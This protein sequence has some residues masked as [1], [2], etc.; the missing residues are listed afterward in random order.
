MKDDVGSQFVARIQSASSVDLPTIVAYA[1]GNEGPARALLNRLRQ[2]GL[3]ERVI[4]SALAV[5]LSWELAQF[6]PGNPNPVLA[7]MTGMF[8]INLTIA[9]SVRDAIQRM[10]GVMWGVGVALLIHYLF[11]LH[12]WTLAL[13][14]AIS[15]AGGRRIGLE[16]SGLS[17]MAASALLVILGAVGSR[18]DNV[19]W[20][21]VVNTLVGTAVGLTLNAVIAPPNYLPSAR[22]AL[23]KL[24]ESLSNLQEDIAATLAT[25]I[26]QE[27][28]FQLL[29]QARAIAATVEKVDDAIGSGEASLKY[30]VLN[31][32]QVITLEVYRRASRALEHAAVQ[33]RVMSRAIHDATRLDSDDIRPDWISP[34]ALGIQIADIFSAI[35][36]SIDHFMS[37]IESPRETTDDEALANDVHRCSRQLTL[38]ARDH[39]DSLIPDGWTLLGEVIALSGQ[40][41]T[42]LT[43]AANEIGTLT[44]Q[45]VRTHDKD[46]D[47]L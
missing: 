6:I 34:D 2:V 17:Q 16:S 25:G 35:S 24:G 43:R 10:L 13:V 30:H 8:S 39:F 5:A 12:G 42:D 21:H 27:S 11:G 20:L 31:S 22:F 36:V 9:G 47:L 26:T 14:V 44:H 15:F 37:L 3:G 29:E 32:R 45:T 4:K 7:A 23:Q 46:G 33:T 18:A 19:A 28:A 41:A 1:T 40:L 38:L